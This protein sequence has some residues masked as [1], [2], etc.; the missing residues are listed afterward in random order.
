MLEKNEF[1]Q[2]IE[3]VASLLGFVFTDT[4]KQEDLSYDPCRHAILKK[5]NLEMSIRDRERAQRC[6]NA[7]K[8]FLLVVTV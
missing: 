8:A 7:V 6:A 5:G 4:T 2:K 3:K 1:N